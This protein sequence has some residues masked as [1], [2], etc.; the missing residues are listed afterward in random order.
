MTCFLSWCWN[1]HP[2]HRTCYL[3]LRAR[4]SFKEISWVLVKQFWGN[5]TKGLFQELTI[6][7]ASQMFG[8]SSL[9]FLRIWF[10]TTASVRETASPKLGPKK[11]KRET[12]PGVHLLWFCRFPAQGTGFCSSWSQNSLLKTAG[13]SNT[14]S[15]VAEK[16]RSTPPPSGR[17]NNILCPLTVLF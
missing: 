2:P 11:D 8:L 1:S 10:T 3:N 9:I 14:N 5:P 16:Q 7:S 12:G 6:E 15:K 13:N 4:R 17:G